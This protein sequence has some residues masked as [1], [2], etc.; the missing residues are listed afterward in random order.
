MDETPTI[1]VRY[2]SVDGYAERMKFK[3]LSEASHFAKKWIG[4]NPE[5]GRKYAVSD[6]GI[7]K[8]EVVGAELKDLFK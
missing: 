8:I 3:T 5:I 7:G 2:S 4:N 6:D 1:T